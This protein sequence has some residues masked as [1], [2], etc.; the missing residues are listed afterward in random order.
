MHAGVQLAGKNCRDQ[1][2]RNRKYV[3]LHDIKREFKIRAFKVVGSI[4]MLD[5]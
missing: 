1:T 4:V 2:Q 5:K 3:C